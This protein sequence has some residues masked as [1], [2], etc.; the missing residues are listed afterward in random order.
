MAPLKIEQ[1]CL[2]CHNDL[3]Y[4]VGDVRGGISVSFDITDIENS[5]HTNQAITILLI[6]VILAVVMGGIFLIARSLYQKLT[7][8][9]KQLQTQADLDGL[10]NLF[11]RR[12]FFEVLEREVERSRRYQNELCC[13]MLDLDHFKSVNDTFGHTGGDLVLK[14][15]AR[16]IRANIRTSDTAAR[17]GGE[18]FIIMM[19]QTSLENA[20][21]AAEKLRQQVAAI[22]VD[23]PKGKITVTASFGVSS[24]DNRLAESAVDEIVRRA[25]G[26]LYEA[27][28][29]GR[30]CVRG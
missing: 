16:M 13:V 18:E 10:T 11:N 29:N 28:A 19:P 15:L 22:A 23:T 4:K 20:R 12:Y 25:D 1:S 6:L 3:G 8:A 5:L 21:A 9:R 30:N 17:Y 2:T 27:K 24:I 14:E 26:A 7:N